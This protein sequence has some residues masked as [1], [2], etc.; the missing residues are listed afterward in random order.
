MAL[1]KGGKTAHAAPSRK[2]RY[3]DTDDEVDL[4]KAAKYTTGS[5]IDIQS[6]GSQQIGAGEG[7]NILNDEH[8]Q[9]LEDPFDIFGVPF[10]NNDLERFEDHYLEPT[11]EPT[12]NGPITF[13]WRTQGGENFDPNFTEIEEE[14]EIINLST[15]KKTLAADDIS[16][17]NS[18][19]ITKYSSIELKIN[20]TVV[21]DSSCG[22]HAFHAYFQQKFSYSKSVKEEILRRTEY[23][24]EE[25]TDRVNRSSLEEGVDDHFRKKHDVFVANAKSVK[26]RTQLY[27][28]VFNVHKLFPSDLD[29][30]MILYRNPLNF[31]LM[32]T[33]G[34]EVRYQVK[35]KRIRLLLRKIMPTEP[36][37]SLEEKLFSLG[38]KAYI[39]YSHGVL[40]NYVIEKG[41]M[42]K[43]FYDVT[44]KPS[45]PKKLFVFFIEHDAFS[46]V[47]N[48]NPFVWH[49]H[50][51]QKITYIVDGKQHPMVP[52]E[53]NFDENDVKRGY[54]DLLNALGVARSNKSVNITMDMYTKYCAVFALDLQADFN[55]QIHFRKDGSVGVEFLFRKALQKTVTVCFL[56]YHDFCLTFQRKPG[57]Y[58]ILVE[59]KP[60][61]ALLED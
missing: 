4:V 38:K 29:F 43:K 26:S 59:K 33:A 21:T 27:L 35:I 54:M 19:P 51:L 47:M 24:F 15:K 28:D 16:V 20:D 13:K 57:K 10:V 22:N 2:R 52:Y 45:L 30:E 61:N 25:E 55:E 37:R 14:F 18:F 58:N 46:G 34:A 50:N 9:R 60:M 39:P 44:L 5:G 23:F 53:L 17:I 36:I 41:N 7:V 3:S 42:T 48:K 40:T 6:G 8:A 32:G 31:C 12:D 1:F 11:Q 49:H 56:S